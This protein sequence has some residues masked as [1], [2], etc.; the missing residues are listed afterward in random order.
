MTNV[1]VIYR[2]PI[3]HP[4]PF[5]M[6]VHQIGMVKGERV[7]KTTDK[8]RSGAS[9][10]EVRRSIP[11]GKQRHDRAEADEPHIVEWWR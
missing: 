1:Y 4:H 11:P 7:V 9:L 3:D 6:R 10:E 5:V 2:E 8:I